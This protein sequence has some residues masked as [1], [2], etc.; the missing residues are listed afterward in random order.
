MIEELAPNI[1]STHDMP[2]TGDQGAE[3][4]PRQY[5]MTTR[6]TVRSLPWPRRAAFFASIACVVCWLAGVHAQPGPTVTANDYARAEGFLGYRTAPLVLNA[7]V[8]A[9]WLPDGRFWYRTTRPSGPEF[10]V[11]DPVKRTR[12]PAFD[13]QQVAAALARASGQTVDAGTL[14]FQQIELSPD[15][16]TVSFEIE[17]KQY[18]CDVQGTKC[19]AADRATGRAEARSPDGRLAAFIRDWNLWV[20]EVP[21]G[22]ETQLTFDGVKHYGYGTDNAG[23]RFSDRPIVKWSPDSRKIATFQQDERQ[24]GEMSVVDT[25][26]GRPTLQT[27][28]YPLPGDAVVAT[29]ERV[30][31]DVERR[32]TT[33]LKMPRDYHRSTVCDDLVCGGEWVDVQWHPRGTEVAFV[34]TSRDHKVAQL[35]VAAASTGEV[36]DIGEERVRTFYESGLGRANWRYLPATNEVIWYS[37]REDWGHLYVWDARTGRETRALTS[38]E[39]NVTQVLHVDER[40]RVVYFTGVGREP[41]RDPYFRH[42]YRVGLDGKGLRLLSAEDGDHDVSFDPSGRFFVDVFSKP[43]VPPVAIVRTDEGQD[44][45]PLERADVSRLRAAGWKPPQP[46]VAKARDGVTDLYGLLFTPTHFDPTRRYPI[47]NNIYPGPQTGSVG[48]RSFVASRGDA[49]AL[50][51]LGFIVVQIDG[52]GTPWRSRT[53]HEVS[54]GDMGDNTLPDQVVAMKDL[55]S[56]YPWIDLSR[57]GIYGHSGGGYAAAGALFRYPDFFKVGV[58]QAGNHDN[59]NYEDDW[60]EK[61]QG[62]LHVDAQGRSNYDNQA[63]Q[64]VAHQLKGK[65]LLAHGTMDTNVPPSSTLLVVDALIRANKDFDLIL[66]PNRGHGFGNEPYMI[67]RR[68]DYFVRHLLG[69]EPPAGFE[70]RPPGDRRPAGH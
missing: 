6:D 11:V 48:T 70:L 36:R 7:G 61:W 38:G 22:R 31:I 51:E 52:M 25:R 40:R 59:R 32:T 19:T 41:G 63:N 47:V 56:R 42:L 54:Y 65:L 15:D 29:I 21:S 33:R 68:W 55:A 53:F 39:W 1:A 69:G 62:L 37:R 49:Q 34:S 9:H 60:A 20:R 16:P 17:L 46:I 5:P 3:G 14:P 44:V 26:V 10:M 12:R 30:I 2:R 66:F 58:A 57:A 64:L 35:R 4:R 28:K 23:W 43:D 24:V 50:A 45:L 18:T 13:H 67:R 8:R 27:W